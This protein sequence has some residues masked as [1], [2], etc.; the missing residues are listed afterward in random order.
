MPS[1]V[2]REN[3]YA[4]LGSLHKYQTGT[5]S[6]TA[7]SLIAAVTGKKIQI[8]AFRFTMAWDYSATAA[9][10][11]ALNQAWLADGSTAL[12][13]LGV[14]P[15]VDTTTVVADAKDLKYDSGMVIL[16]SAGVKGTAATAINIDFTTTSTILTYS[17]DVWYDTVD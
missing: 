8:K 14:T 5:A 1:P 6:S 9:A 7:A 2:F 11:T 10:D 4:S 13:H 12:L 15:G 17:I 3:Y 16:P